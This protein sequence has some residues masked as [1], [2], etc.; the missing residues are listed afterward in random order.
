MQ[1]LS[2]TRRR[3]QKPGEARNQWLVA[4]HK[5]PKRWSKGDEA[6]VSQQR[7]LN[8]HTVI[9][10]S[11]S[12]ERGEEID[13]NRRPTVDTTSRPAPREPAPKSRAVNHDQNEGGL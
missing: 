13:W 1:R 11:L 9:A 3:N 10:N 8:R 4:G 2:Q 5:P 7:K 12:E 6:N